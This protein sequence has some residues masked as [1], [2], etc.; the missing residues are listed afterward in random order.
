[1]KLVESGGDGD[2]DGDGDDG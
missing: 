2:G 1:M